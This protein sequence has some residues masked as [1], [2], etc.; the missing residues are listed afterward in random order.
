MTGS[1]STRGALPTTALGLARLRDEHGLPPRD[2]HRPRDRHVRLLRGELARL[3]LT[4]V[5]IDAHEVRRKAHR[6]LQKSDRRDALEESLALFA[7]F[8]PEEFDAD[9]PIIKP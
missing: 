2:A 7:R 9:E 3:D 1:S 8:V 4:P 5:V 6:P